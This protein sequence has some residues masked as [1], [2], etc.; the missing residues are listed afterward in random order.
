MIKEL[1]FDFFKTCIHQQGDQ[2]C[3][4]LK[5]IG[6]FHQSIEQRKVWILLLVIVI[7]RVQ[8]FENFEY[9]D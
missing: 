1:F 4:N 7:I 2:L 6:C 5:A 3:L 8:M 9:C